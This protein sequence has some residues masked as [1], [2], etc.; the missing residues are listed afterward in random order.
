MP[1]QQLQ[2]IENEGL[3]DSEAAQLDAVV[4]DSDTECT[5]SEFELDRGI[6]GFQCERLRENTGTVSVG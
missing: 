1:N 3:L 2:A 6:S 4:R 5:E